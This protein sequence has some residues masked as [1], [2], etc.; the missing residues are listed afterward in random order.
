MLAKESSSDLRYD[1]ETP[2][3]KDQ[4]DENFPV[5]SIIL[6]PELRPHV[7]CFYDFARAADDI[8]DNPE[9]SPQD[10]I[11]RL[12]LFEAVLV[13]ETG[14]PSLPKAEKLRISLGETGVTNRHA[15]DLL[16][17]FRQDATKL[18][19]ETWQELVDYCELSANPV[20]RYLID[21]HGDDVS[22]YRSSDALC[23]VLQVLN[24]L[25]DCV[26]DWR[27]MDRV[28]IP[29]S[30]LKNAGTSIDVLGQP[31]SDDAF[32]RVLDQMLDECDALLGIAESLAPSLRTRRFSVNSA[33]IVALAG[34]LSHRVRNQDPI[35]TRVALTKK[36]FLLAGMKGLWRGLFGSRAAKSGIAS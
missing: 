20:G 25:Q 8:A 24:H 2:S 33:V 30:M 9:L 5:A 16:A 22:V 13:G 32:R 35:A 19:Y 4:E 31:Q 21:L 34:R 28:Y 12:D 6:A 3:G 26:D 11:E 29:L 27:E 14:T 36:D 7:K 1:V 18:R 15:R 23:T 17:A 10:K